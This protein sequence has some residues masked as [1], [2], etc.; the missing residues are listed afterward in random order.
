[1]YPFGCN[2]PI[3][4]CSF[5][6]CKFG[7]Q[8]LTMRK[9][10]MIL[11]S[12]IFMATARTQP[13]N[14]DSL[15]D[16]LSKSKP[17][18]NTLQQMNDL[19]Y[20][21]V[22]FHP[23]SSYYFGRQEYLLAGQLNNFAYQALGLLCM[24]KGLRQMGNYPMALEYA[25]QGLKI[26]EQKNLPDVETNIVS[27]ISFIYY[28]QKDG[29]NCIAY[30]FRCLDLNKN[31]PDL[32]LLPDLYTQISQGYEVMS[33]YDS[34]LFY[35]LKTFQL[36]SKEH[37]ERQIVFCYENLA[38]LYFEL[39]QDSTALT[40]YR[41]AFP[42]FVSHQV[43]E[44]TC[45]AAQYLAR[46]FERENKPDSAIWYG[47]LSL[48]LSRTSLL[49][50]RQSEASDFLSSFYKNRH[51]PDSALK[52]LEL[53]VALK[54]SLFN[55]EKT[56]T[57]ANLTFDEGM[58]QQEIAAQK[59]KA[60]DDRV[61]NLQLLAIG[62]FIPIFF[63]GVLFLSR[64]KVK[65]RIVEFLGILSLLLFFEFIT[66]LIY[67]FVSKLT[68]EN[69][70]WEMLFLVIIAASLEPLNF[71]LEHWVKGHL[72]HKTIAVPVPLTVENSLYDVG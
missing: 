5:H 7:I 57:M 62:V 30:A 1:M 10:S 26:S 3:N 19:A 24:S 66:D 40:Y 54:D 13:Y 28:F 2:I 61:R 39:H 53:N 35:E 46:I 50:S 21:Y 63:L 27:E 34:S 72:V 38:D 69:P 68:N 16:L 52:Y 9:F 45:E 6:F 32:H 64:T 25:L 42:Y 14:M 55:N 15:H 8:T 71:R 49:T 65:P 18:T 37:D 17:D 29:K 22:H 11:F 58:R 70:I 59:M 4:F 47:Q 12:W 31:K 56:R 23:D 20:G 44:G 51:Q 48:R 67:P 36:A 41:Q 43:D 60:E 33:R